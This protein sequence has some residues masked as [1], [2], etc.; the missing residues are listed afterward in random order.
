V[1]K[2][3]ETGLTPRPASKVKAPLIAECLANFECRVVA[4]QDIGD[5]RVYFGEVVA[6][7]QG[8]AAHPH[9]LVV[10]PQAGY[11]QVLE[12]GSFRLGAVRG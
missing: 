6:C 10:G 5:H 4:T 7:W 2:F 11:D 8:E 3:A 12:E 1:D 9:L